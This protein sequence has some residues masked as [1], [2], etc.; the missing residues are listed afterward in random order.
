MDRRRF[1]LTSLAGAVAAPL[2]AGAQAAGKVWRI[3]FLA[4][5]TVPELDAALR[6]LRELGW[7]EGQHFVFEYRSADSKLEKVSERAAELVRR[8]CRMPLV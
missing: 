1:L 8:N 5:T 4:G 3:G 7:T 6:G 2:A